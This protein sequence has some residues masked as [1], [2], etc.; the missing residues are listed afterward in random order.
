MGVAKR[1]PLAH[2]IV[3]HVSSSR[4]T[5]GGRLAHIGGVHLHLADHVGEDL[6]RAFDRVDGVEERLLVFLHVLVVGQRQRLHHGK[7]RHQVAVDPAGLP[8]HQFRHIRVLLLRHDGGAGAEAVG[9]VDKLELAGGPDDQLLGEAGE[10]HH[11]DRGGSDE[12][13]GKIP[14][15]HRVERIAR[16]RRKVEQFGHILPVDGKGGAGQG[17]G[18]EGQDV[19]PFEAVLQPLLVTLAHLHVGEQVVGEEDRL[20][21]LQVGVAGHDDVKVAFRLTDE[22]VDEQVEIGGNLDDFVPQVEADIQRHLIVAGTAGMEALACLADLRREARLDVHMD[23][24]QADG[25]VEMTCLDLLENLVQAMFDRCHIGRRDDP[26]LAE[27]AGMGHGAADVLVVEALV[28]IDGGGELLDEFVGRLG[29]TP[30]PEFV[31]CHRCRSLDYLF[32]NGDR[33]TARAPILAASA[34]RNGYFRRSLFI[35][36]WMRMRRELILMNPSA[37]AWL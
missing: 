29:E 23:I 11:Q 22:R 25:E 5:L 2:Q 33:G 26:L 10:V 4:E 27:H 8:P 14:V 16:Y 20:G 9:K 18:A 32:L 1:H 36:V 35:R 28:E 7:K 24:F 13:Q 15:R 31:F 12:L 6:E 34:V 21:S 37:S 30:A 19:H 17:P 3:G